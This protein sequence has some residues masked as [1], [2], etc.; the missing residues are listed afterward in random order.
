MSD[1]GQIYCVSD[2]AVLEDLGLILSRGES[3]K[4]P[5]DKIIGSLDLQKARKLGLVSVV[6]PKTLTVKPPETSGN[7][8][9]VSRAAV[10][11]MAPHIP[12]PTR[13]T[14][15]PTTDLAPVLGF[16]HQILEELK[17][18]RAEISRRPVSS[19]LP[20]ETNASLPTVSGTD[21][22]TFIPTIET[23]DLGTVNVQTTSGTSSGSIDEAMNLLR[24]KKEKRK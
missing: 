11:P 1:E 21:I 3:A 23:K 16:L 17:F 19:N 12:E 13:N 14:A 20:P 8:R 24:S 22:P 10:S 5:M 6:L 9:A 18:L 7:V 4:L 2:S 15:V